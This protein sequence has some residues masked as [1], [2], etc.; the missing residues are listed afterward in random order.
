MK[1]IIDWSWYHEKILENKNKLIFSALNN[2]DKV[3]EVFNSSL[4]G[5]SEKEADKRLKEYG[6]NKIPHKN[7]KT[8]FKRIAEGFINPFTLI[9]FALALISIFTDILIP[10]FKNEEISFLTVIIISTM[11]T[12]SGLIRFIQ[13]YKSDNA[14]E[15]L[16]NMIKS[17]SIVLRENIKKEINSE[18]LTVGD[19]VFINAGNI[20]PA[21]IRIIES[22]NLTVS[23]SVLTGE[24]EPLEKNNSVCNTGARAGPAGPPALPPAAS[25][26]RAPVRMMRV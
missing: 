22:N 12:V 10:F 16:L 4:E 19:I 21:D 20:I 23:Q 26:R 7:K 9:L 8:I 18:N 1:N 17:S 25:P 5:I 3:L 11:I 2:T 15:N 13:E 14:S 6:L 24:S